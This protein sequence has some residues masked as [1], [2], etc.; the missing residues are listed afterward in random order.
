MKRVW[1]FVLLMVFS[2]TFA[3]GAAKVSAADPEVTV[4]PSIL[5]ANSPALI[6]VDPHTMKS[7]IRII[8]T[9]L[10]LLL[11]FLLHRYRILAYKTSVVPT[12]FG[13]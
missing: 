10:H 11:H 12:L 4:I 3:A 8:Q 9:A 2:L 7:P 5:S 13:I 1:L 6:K